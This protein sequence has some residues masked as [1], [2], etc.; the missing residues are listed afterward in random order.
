MQITRAGFTIAITQKV[1]SQVL[2]YEIRFFRRIEGVTLFNKMK[3]HSSEI[4]KSLNI[5][6]YFSKFKNIS[7]DGLAMWAECLRKDCSN[8][9]YLPEQLGEDQLDDLELG[10]PITL[11]ISGGIVWNFIQTKWWKWWKTVKCC[12]LLPPQPS[13]PRARWTNYIEDLGWN[14]LGL[15]PNEMMEMMEDREVLRAAAP[16]TLTEKRVHVAPWARFSRPRVD[17]SVVYPPAEGRRL[18]RSC[19]FSL[20]EC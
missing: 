1:R 11:R 14:R 2:A 15:H 20:R 5:E 8:K 16:A 12:E 9:L 7:W 19:K 10:G 13:R 4:R 6:P 18:S 3:V 17:D